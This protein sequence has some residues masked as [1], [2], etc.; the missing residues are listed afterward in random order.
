MQQRI[1]THILLC[2]FDKE[3]QKLEVY[4]VYTIGDCYVVMGFVNALDRNPRREAFNVIKI[5]R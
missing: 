5:L 1:L 2:Y 3:C 4:K